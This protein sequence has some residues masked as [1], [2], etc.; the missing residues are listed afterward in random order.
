MS[1]FNVLQTHDA[2]AFASGC[3]AAA[4]SVL[5]FVQDW[6]GALLGVPIGVPVAG[7]A[8]ALFGLLFREALSPLMLW[9]NIAA[10][11][12]LASVVAPLAQHYLGAP[13]PLTAALAGVLAFLAQYA[14]PWLKARREQ[15]LDAAAGKVI[16][17]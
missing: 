6:S 9:V 4:T 15:L 2:T 14:Q 10:T 11:S 1:R 7:F 8:G 17:K 5:S 13:A 12:V 3:A 16:P